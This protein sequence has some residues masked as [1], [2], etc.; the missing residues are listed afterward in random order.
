MLQTDFP[1]GFGKQGHQSNQSAYLTHKIC[2]HCSNSKFTQLK[3]SCSFPAT[4][5]E[6][7][8][9]EQDVNKKLAIKAWQP[10]HQHFILHWF[11][12]SQSGK[13]PPFIITKKKKKKHHHKQQISRIRVALLFTSI[14]TRM[15]KTLPLE[16]FAIAHSN[17]FTPSHINP[18]I[19][20]PYPASQ[21]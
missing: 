3:A 5:E 4:L 7:A 6:T 21:F 14:E 2:F 18:S 20:P 8:A 17:I 16:S 12:T 13:K 9:A 1:K 15:E 11:Y 10:Q 19:H